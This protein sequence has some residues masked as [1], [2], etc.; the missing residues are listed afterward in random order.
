MH[1]V[2]T[3]SGHNTWHLDR[4]RWNDWRKYDENQR[5]GTLDLYTNSSYLLVGL[6][7]QGSNSEFLRVSTLLSALQFQK[8]VLGRYCTATF[9]NVASVVGVCRAAMDS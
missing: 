5:S 1:S 6:M 4:I 9:C 8:V 7:K 2:A 3:V